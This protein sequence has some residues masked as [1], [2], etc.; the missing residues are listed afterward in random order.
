[1]TVNCKKTAILVVR[2]KMVNILFIIFGIMV[3]TEL[4]R[5]L[6]L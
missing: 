6:V 1:M 3:F 4:Q 5:A 2:E